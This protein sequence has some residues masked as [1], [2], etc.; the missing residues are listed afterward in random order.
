[1]K[2][3]THVGTTGVSPSVHRVY[4]LLHQL[5]IFVDGW[6]DTPQVIEYLPELEAAR[7][8]P[9]MTKISEHSNVTMP[10]E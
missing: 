8:F 9:M 5:W 10:E 6:L 4:L 1:M 2:A 7:T 3:P